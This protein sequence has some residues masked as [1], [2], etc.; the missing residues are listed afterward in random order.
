MTLLLAIIGIHNGHLPGVTRGVS[1]SVEE[2]IG[3]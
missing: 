1:I 3:E 2:A